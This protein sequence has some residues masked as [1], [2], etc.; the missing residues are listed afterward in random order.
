MN[1][2]IERINELIRQE[3]GRLIREEIEL[4]AESLVTITKVDTTPDM[5]NA[6]IMITTFPD[7]LRGTILEIL[8]KNQHKLHLLLKKNLQTKFIPNIRFIIDEQE[9]F[10]NQI[11]KILDEISS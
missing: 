1:Q 9:L 10:A 7:N 2:R 6:G 8:R 4:P 5:K 11:D 3:L